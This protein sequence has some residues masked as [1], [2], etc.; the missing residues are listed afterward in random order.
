MGDK[1][2]EC[3]E[4]LCYYVE[5]ES[6]APAAPRAAQPNSPYRSN[7]TRSALSGRSCATLGSR[8]AGPGSYH[9]QQPIQRRPSVVKVKKR[10]PLPKNLVLMSLIKANQETSQ[11]QKLAAKI[12]SGREDID[13]GKHNDD[14]EEFDVHLRVFLESRVC[15]TYMVTTRDGLPV[16]AHKPKPSQ[17]DKYNNAESKNSSIN[18]YEEEFGSMSSSIN[19][20]DK[21]KSANFGDHVQVV[22]IEDGWAILAR[23]NGYIT[24]DESK[25]IRVSGPRDKVCR[26]EGIL[27]KLFTYWKEI[28]KNRNKVQNLKKELIKELSNASAEDNKNNN[29]LTIV[30]A[31]DSERELLEANLE[32]EEKQRLEAEEK[33]LREEQ[34][35]QDAAYAR[36][37]AESRY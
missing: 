25:L 29:D 26:S 3:R 1:C 13:H 24:A 5:D 34:E 35:K 14:E 2:Y 11:T 31:T 33:K 6:A 32:K 30:P 8:R 9:Q 18:V 28:E 12:L 22:A 23:Q 19:G 4:S 20:K 7:N 16:Y 10:F 17:T 36:S 27:Y 21:P 37:L 15:G